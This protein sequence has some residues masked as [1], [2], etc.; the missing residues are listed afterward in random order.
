MSDDLRAN[1][2]EMSTEEL[3]DILR[4]R[5]PEQWRP[6]VFGIVEALLRE[7]G[8]DVAGLGPAEEPPVP[9]YAA[10]DVAASFNDSMKAA[11]AR[12]ALK[13]SGIDAW[14]S[15]EHFVG[16]M[17]YMGLSVGIDL[18]VHK[19]DAPAARE[20]LASLDSGSAAL[21]ADSASCPQ[22]QSTETE[23]DGP[24]MRCRSC[25]HRWE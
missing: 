22:C 18:L 20:V 19:E 5:D 11:L 10:L 3:S 21:S 6:E 12:M 13:E 8:V 2:A 15:T 23:P 1:L 25:G 14:L 9:E 17:P 7:R 16:V 24:A 4:R